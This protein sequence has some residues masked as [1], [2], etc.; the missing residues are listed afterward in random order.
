MSGI[1][2]NHFM[3]HMTKRLKHANNFSK[4]ILISVIIFIQSVCTQIQETDITIGLD[5]SEFKKIQIFIILDTF[6]TTKP[7]PTAP[8]HPKNSVAKNQKIAAINVATELLRQKAIQS[9]PPMAINSRQK[10]TT[11]LAV[12]SHL[13]SPASITR[14]H[15]V[16]IYL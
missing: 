12:H 4:H 8:P 3:A 1:G 6:I 15:K 16:K 9:A 11:Q 14:A 10:L 5:I 2:T 7:A 13:A